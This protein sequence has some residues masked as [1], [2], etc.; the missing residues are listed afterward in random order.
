MARVEIELPDQFQ[1]RTEIPIRIGDIN[2]GGHLGNDAVLSIAQ[3]A[4]VRFLRSHGWTELDVQGVGLAMVDAAVVYRAEGL[5]G[6]VLGVE[7]AP[8]DVRT[9]GFDLLYRLSDLAG[10]GEIARVKTGLVFFDYAARRIVRMP[11]AF[12]QVVA[13]ASGSDG[14]PGAPRGL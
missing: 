2:Y 3:E 13:P 8:A 4:R 10:G 14:A 1:F 5:Y 11:E 6:M 12:R 9:R 7:L